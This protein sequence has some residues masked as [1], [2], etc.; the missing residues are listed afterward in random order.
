VHEEKFVD[1]DGVRT[2]YLEAGSGEPMLLIHGGNFGRYCL[3]EDWEP[4]IDLLGEHFRVLAIDKIGCGFTDNP[5]ADEGYVIGSVV[6]HAHRFL[7]ALGVPAAHL[8]GHSR[9]GYATTRLALEHPEMALSL[10]IV[11][12]STLMTPPNPQYDAWDREA[13]KLPDPRDQVRYLVTVNSFSGDHVDEAFVDVMARAS[14][15]PKSVEAAAK[16]RDG[17]VG[18]FNE[19]L[20][21][22]QAETQDW[23]RSGRLRCPTLVVWAYN[24]P[25]ATMERCGIPCM[26]LV[27]TNVP[28]SEMHILTEAGHYCYREQPVAFTDVV[29]TFIRRN[30]AVPTTRTAPG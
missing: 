22:R 17:L 1:V 16:M 18:Q 4:V 10:T 21:R 9:G 7:T 15:L 20:V 3:A 12:S 25:S 30:A 23:I 24:D 8:V 28:D 26:D 19:D 29:T 6:D 2:R 27:L 5:P 14:T 13:A 11:D